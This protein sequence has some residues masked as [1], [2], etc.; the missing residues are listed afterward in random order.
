V[1]RAQWLRQTSPP[2]LSWS[3]RT[4]REAIGT[5]LIAIRAGFQELATACRGGEVWF[6]CVATASIGGGSRVGQ[7]SE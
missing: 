1:G 2:E 6:G 4:D 5:A 7:W 3:R